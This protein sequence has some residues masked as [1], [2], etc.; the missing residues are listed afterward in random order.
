MTLRNFV[1]IALAAFASTA[2]PNIAVG[3]P[4]PSG[5]D[6]FMALTAG[7]QD[8]GVST[9]LD[10][11][12]CASTT[13]TSF[14]ADATGIFTNSLHATASLSTTAM[15][16][17]LHSLPAPALVNGSYIPG[18]E[19]WLSG[20]FFD[21]LTLSGPTSTV[22]IG[23]SIHSEGS[24]SRIPGGF[25]KAS[26]FVAVGARNPTPN[27]CYCVLGDFLG[28]P[29]VQDGGS[30]FSFLHG[31]DSATVNQTATANFTANVG[32][33]FELGYEFLI[34]GSQSDIDFGN[35]FTI[36]FIV[37]DGYTLTSSRAADATAAPE[38]ATLALLGLGLAGLGF[39]RRKRAG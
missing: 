37:P 38:P 22:Q 20:V 14:S 39:M 36:D 16:A 6:T 13:S 21:N 3:H 27:D 35:T 1:S 12:D 30:F 28:T 7:G 4:L 9:S 10:A 17:E 32:S 2:L 31:P 34:H 25:S 5:T 29:I 11:V 18:G 8:C 15:H 19:G 26:W 23:I 24:A 33:A